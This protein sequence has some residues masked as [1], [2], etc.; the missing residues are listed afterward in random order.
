MLN[1]G[2]DSDS[3]L[4]QRSVQD[5]QNVKRDL[6]SFRINF[7]RHFLDGWHRVTVVLTTPTTGIAPDVFR[8]RPQRRR[9]VRYGQI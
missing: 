3:A 9:G 8:G 1:C 5:N 2:E 4:L 7:S 6:W